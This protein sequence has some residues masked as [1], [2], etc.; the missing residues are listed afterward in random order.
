MERTDEAWEIERRESL[1]K[2]SSAAGAA[3]CRRRRVGR[4][5]AGAGAGRTAR[6][7]AGAGAGIRAAAHGAGGHD[8]RECR[9]R[10]A[11]PAPT[12]P[13]PTARAARRS[14]LPRPQRRSRRRRTPPAPADPTPAPLPVRG[15]V[16][17]LSNPLLRTPSSK[18]GAGQFGREYGKEFHGTPPGGAR[19]PRRATQVQTLRG[20]EW[21]A[22]PRPTRSSRR[23]HR[24]LAKWACSPPAGRAPTTTM[25]ACSAA[26]HGRRRVAVEPLARARRRAGAGGVARPHA[27]PAAHSEADQ[28][29][30][31]PNRPARVRLLRHGSVLREARRGV[32]GR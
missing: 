21:S 19:A 4:R 15:V 3:R 20:V 18:S 1:R 13:L 27:R 16:S 9:P 7:G 12:R 2:M 30:S 24:Q 6:A 17:P 11:A 14:D 10:R 29:P 26:P 5:A 8:G 32:R 22:T 31:S 25:E 23:A 28:P